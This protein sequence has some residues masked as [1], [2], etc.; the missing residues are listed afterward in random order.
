MRFFAIS[1]L[2]LTAI[3]GSFW[4]TDG[5]GSGMGFATV[6]FAVLGIGG[7]VG[8]AVRIKSLNDKAGR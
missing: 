7:F 5:P 3:A 2:I 1:F 4:I 6:L 8:E